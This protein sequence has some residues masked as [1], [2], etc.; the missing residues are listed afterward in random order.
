MFY[1]ML[2]VCKR[3]TNVATPKSDL[4]PKSDQFER[5]LIGKMFGLVTI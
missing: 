1:S 2:S 3:F 5:F 4:K